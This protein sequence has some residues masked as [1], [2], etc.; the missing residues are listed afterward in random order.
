MAIW[1]FSTTALTRQLALQHM[2][3]A[4]LLLRPKPIFWPR[5]SYVAATFLNVAMMYQ[6]IEKNERLLGEEHIQTAVCYHALAIAFNCMGAFKLSHQACVSG[7]IMCFLLQIGLNKIHLTDYCFWFTQHE[8][9]TYDILVKQ[10]GEDSR[11]RHSQN[12]MKT[13]KMRELQVSEWSCYCC[14][15][16]IYSYE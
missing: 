2:S 7:R 14:V 4:L 8:K 6:D 3:R 12:W 5:S 13:F 15:I 1:L 11:T 9:K 10:L 16:S